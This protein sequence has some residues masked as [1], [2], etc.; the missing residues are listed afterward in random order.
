MAPH[1]E[2]IH[3]WLLAHTPVPASY[4]A[5]AEGLA[6]VAFPLS[7]SGHTVPGSAST[8]GDTPAKPSLRRF[9]WPLWLPRPLAVVLMRAA[10]GQASASESLAPGPQSPLYP[11]DL[12]FSPPAG[13]LAS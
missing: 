3:Q 6:A 11:E 10:I 12:G 1:S 9:R 4:A 5:N 2:P 8:T 13:R 7:A